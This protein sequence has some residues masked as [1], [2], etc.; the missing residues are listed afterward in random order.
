MTTLTVNK[1]APAQQRS[2]WPYAIIATFVLFACFI[3]YMVKQ[4]MG[5]SVDLVSKDYYEQELQHQQRMNAVARTAAL[6]GT[7]T[8]THTAGT[9]T[10]QLP[11]SL[12]GQEVS[13]KV[14]FFRPSDQTL[15]FSVPLRPDATGA[16]QLSTTKLKPG[17]WRVRLDFEAGGQ[18]YFVEKSMVAGN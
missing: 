18:P 2:L 8:L 12:R 15:D 14:Q 9:L 11:A 17:Y 6:P 5:T 7:V 13:G 3:G 10:L 16:Q 4:A 1:P